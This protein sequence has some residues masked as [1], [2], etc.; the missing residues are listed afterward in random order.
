[1]RLAPLLLCACGRIGFSGVAP[2]GD[3]ITADAA[4]DTSID[5]LGG[6]TLAFNQEHRITNSTVDSRFPVIA[7]N[8]TGFGVAWRETAATNDIYFSGLD[9]DAAALTQTTI[10]GAQNGQDNPALL[11]T[12]TDFA[13]LWRDGRASIYQMWFERVSNS[14]VIVTPEVQIT[15]GTGDSAAT[16][17]ASN[18]TG[19]GTVRTDESSG[20]EIKFRRIDLTGAPIGGDTLIGTTTFQFDRA[21]IVYTGSGYGIAWLRAGATPSIYLTRLDANGAKVGTDTLVSTG[22]DRSGGPIVVWTGSEYGVVWDQCPATNCSPSTEIWFARVSANGTRLTTPRTLSSTA[23]QAS[24]PDMVWSGGSYWIT[25]EAGD[26]SVTRLDASG[27][28]VIPPMRASTVTAG[29]QSPRMVATSTGL[30]IVWED[31][32]SGNG[33]V[34]ARTITFQ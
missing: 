23:G 13:V 22:T 1:M 3:A 32:R 26:I 29:A 10:V 19:Y 9:P 15:G 16:M 28:T 17:F 2:A 27:A 4:S 14:G 5:A 25:W 12:G 8:G 21:S 24:D 18:G 11:W 20:T 34:Y 30:A 7:Y 6:V 33:E 31:L